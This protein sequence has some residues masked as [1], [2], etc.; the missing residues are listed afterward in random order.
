MKNST[1]T[2]LLLTMLT[3][4][5]CTTVLAGGPAL[6]EIGTPASVG[7]A[8]AL[9]PVNTLDPSAAFTNPAG[10]SFIEGDQFR[11]GGQY[12][13]AEMHFESGEQSTSNGSDGGNAGEHSPIPGF[14][15]NMHMNERWTVGFGMSGAFGGGLDYGSDFVG[16]Y[17]AHKSIL[18]AAAITGSA[19]YKVNEQLSFGFG[20]SAVNVALELEIA[21]PTPGPGALTPETDGLVHIDEIDDWAEQF[22]LGFIYKINPQFTLGAVYHSEVD[23]TLEGDVRFTNVMPIPFDK[24]TV[25][26][27]LSFAD[28]IDV[29]LVYSPTPDVNYIFEVDYENWD[30]FETVGLEIDANGDPILKSLTYN[31]KDTYRAAF[32]VMHFLPDNYIISGGVSYD[33]SVVDDKDRRVDLPLDDQMRFSFAFGRRV[34]GEYD[35]SLA[36]SF[37]NMGDGKIDQTMFA[38]TPFE[39][40]VQGE[41]ETN[42]LIALSASYKYYF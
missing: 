39:H 27:K 30:D 23:V 9:H 17:Q 12:L 8:G 5:Y 21:T 16:R 31:F 37:V 10:M 4:T 18:T 2:T 36:A 35:W 11:F 19:S 14:Y 33:S 15:G 3:A 22:H 40:R 6:R 28:I 25:D 34:A 24:T 7:T 41:F 13:I 26:A 42:H 20:L 32:A 1:K 38:D 29:G